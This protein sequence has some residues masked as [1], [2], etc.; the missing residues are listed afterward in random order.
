MSEDQDKALEAKVAEVAG[1]VDA[2]NAQLTKQIQAAHSRTHALQVVG[3]I[4]LAIVVAYLSWL[5]SKV[6]G[7]VG[8]PEGLA[9]LIKTKADSRLPDLL[10]KIE[11]ALNDQ[12]P[13]VVKT[14][15]ETLIGE[16]PKLR[17]RLENHVGETLDALM[18][19]LDADMDKTIDEAIRDHKKDLQPLVAKATDPTKAAELQEEFKDIF[20]DI[21]GKRFD[22]H[23]E[24]FDKSMTA[25]ERRLDRLHIGKNLTPEEQ[26]EKELIATVMIAIDEAIREVGGMPEHKDEATKPVEKAARKPVKKAQTKAET[27]APAAPKTT[28]PAK[29]KKG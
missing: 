27:K 5:T 23:L 24:K 14:V 20:E 10:E 9:V 1:A 3:I 13:E 2:L 4:F 6:R 22:E 29:A 15:R 7:T 11:R 19:K 12:A 17:T 26:L 18:D 28:E 16:M 21:V 25:I 8:D